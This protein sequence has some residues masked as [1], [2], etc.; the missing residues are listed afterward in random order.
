[1]RCLVCDSTDKWESVDQHRMKPAGMMICNNCGFVSYPSKWKSY[2]EI[3]EHYRAS[4]RN[5]PNS[6][7]VFAGQRKNHF[8]AKF[9][10][11]VVGVWLKEKKKPVI[12]EVGAAFG[13][14]LKWFQT[15][16]PEAEIYGTELTTSFRRNAF[17]E[18]GIN[19]TEEIDLSKKYD[20]IMSYK[21]AEHQLD[22]DQR[23]AEYRGALTDEGL[24]Y[25]SV[26]TWFN[27][28][29]NFGLGGFDLEYYY[30][31]NHVNV[32]TEK[33]FENVLLKAG[34]EIIKKDS[35]IYDS[36]YLCKKGH[37]AALHPDIFEDAAEI[38]VRMAKIKAAFLACHESRYAEA[39]AMW[40]EYPT[41]WQNF[42][43][44]N[45]KELAEKGW[46]YFEEHF[47]RNAIAA[48]PNSADMVTVAADFALR[49]KQ[50]ARASEYCELA[51]SMKPENP[52]VLLFLTN[53]M[54]EMALHAKSEKERLHYF[55]QAR[56]VA[57]H[58]KFT[59][60]EHYRDAE[61]LILLYNSHLPTPHEVTP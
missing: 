1:M 16:L 36:T 19:L 12:C 56:E 15:V 23:L 3:K 44:M 27:S 29:N 49:S 8:H 33:L 20:L 60:L 24:L 30:D 7:N 28:M 21:V 32:W 18:F 13:M 11:D 26:P 59:S 5:P 37:P 51:L 54:R 42:L 6:Q 55:N 40:P 50:Y 46:D 47:I 22:V 35:M 45:R 52:I 39:L 9:L 58:L 14:A 38:K 4:Y 48:C 53:T 61:N 57:A 41:A 10:H 31:P 43:E 25:I 2:E 34:F 17:H